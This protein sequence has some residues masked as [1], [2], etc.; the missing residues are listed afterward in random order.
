MYAEKRLKLEI[1]KEAI[2]KKAVKPSRRNEMAQRAR[3]E[4][5]TSIRLDGFPKHKEDD[6]EQY[7]YRGMQMPGKE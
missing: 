2:E 4:F 3:N 6:L 5:I 7:K 1:A